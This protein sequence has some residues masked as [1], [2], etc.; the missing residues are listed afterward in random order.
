MVEHFAASA[1]RQVSPTCLSLGDLRPTVDSVQID[2]IKSPRMSRLAVNQITTNRWS[3][4]QDLQSYREE[5]FEA[6]GLWRP[7]FARFEDEDRA[8][9]LVRESGLA[10]FEPFLCRR[11]YRSQRLEFF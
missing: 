7:K 11:I 2:S 5:G 8:I 9:E 4:E 10:D 3:L 1:Q 6:A